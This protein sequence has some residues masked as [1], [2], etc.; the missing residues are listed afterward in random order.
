MI[1]R[2]TKDWKVTFIVGN[3][4]YKTFQEARAALG[5]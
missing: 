2:I 3:S 5:V 1:I 4:E